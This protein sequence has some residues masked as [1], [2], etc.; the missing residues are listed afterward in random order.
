VRLEWTASA[1]SDLA[2]VF[3]HI[4]AENFDAAVDQEDRIA[5]AADRLTVHPMLGREGRWSQTRELVVPR[6]PYLVIYRILPDAVELLRI[7]HGAQ[8]WPPKEG[9]ER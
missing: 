6:T 1:R 5:A 4:A 3:F 8:D 7:I 9:L 2:N